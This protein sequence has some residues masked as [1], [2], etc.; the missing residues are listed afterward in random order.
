MTKRWSEIL[1]EEPTKGR[2]RKGEQKKSMNVFIRL[3]KEGE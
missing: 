1:L 2:D 3:S